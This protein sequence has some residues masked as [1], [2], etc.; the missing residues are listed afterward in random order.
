MQYKDFIGEVQNRARLATQGEAV[1]ATRA[2]LEVLGQRLFGDEANNL[3]AQLPE[4]IGY[5][6]RQAKVKESFGVDEFFGRVSEREGV[7]QPDAVFHARAVIAVLQEA[8]T[9]GEV[10]DALAQLPDEYNQLFEAGSEGEM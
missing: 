2:T 8:V 5:Y 9:P 7:D 6:M 3:A 4:E 10:N 1:K